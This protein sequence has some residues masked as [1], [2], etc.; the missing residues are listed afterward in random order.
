[1]WWL[2]VDRDGELDLVTALDP[3]DYSVLTHTGATLALPQPT[4]PVEYR[5]F[6][7][8]VTDPDP[9]TFGVMDEWKD[10][11][12]YWSVRFTEYEAEPGGAF[13]EVWSESTDWFGATFV[14]DMDGD[15]R[16]EVFEDFR[17]DVTRYENLIRMSSTGA[18]TSAPM[19]M[20]GRELQT[21]TP[22][23]DL[24]GDG[25]A[26]LVLGFSTDD[27]WGTSG[28]GDDYGHASLHLGSPLG[29]GPAVWRFQPSDVL[30][31]GRSV[32]RVPDT[33]TLVFAVFHDREDRNGEL[34]STITVMEDASTP[35]YAITQRFPEP[36]WDGSAPRL[37]MVRH[38]DGALELV[39]TNR[40]GGW[41]YAWDPSTRR[42]DE[43]P[44]A[45][46]GSS[47]CW[48]SFVSRPGARSAPWA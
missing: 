44:V 23:G 24:D 16:S 38:D 39:V 26:D 1:V 2:D 41:W 25:S 19:E 22:V 37:T 6:S 29:I 9:D 35:E 3:V 18:L 17:W 31:A 21:V 28:E 30:S 7:T 13:T 32:A 15:G 47:E 27:E 46:F 11:A 45:T 34:E 12:G 20:L 10:D 40:Y 4:E 14:G 5:D 8:D 36:D 33:D 48:T 43:T 42:F